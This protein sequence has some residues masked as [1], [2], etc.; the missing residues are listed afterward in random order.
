MNAEPQFTNLGTAELRKRHSVMIEGGN[1]P[2]AKVMD[3]H[4]IDRYLM[5]GLL[6]LP[7]HRA[8]ELLLLQASTA[9]FW[10]TGVDLSKTR[11]PNG[12]RS[13]VPFGTFPFGRT[14]SLVRDRY[15]DR[16]AYVVQ[17]VVCHERDVASNDR[18]T[19]CLKESLKLIHALK[20]EMKHRSMS[21]LREAVKKGT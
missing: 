5:T 11:V 4:L 12:A 14:I 3:Q 1:V 10:P 13:Y 9:G 18:L 2:R 21:R 6:T 15:G 20:F 19:K 16:H 7:E 17:E 8:G